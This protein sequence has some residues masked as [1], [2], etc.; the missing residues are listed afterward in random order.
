MAARKPTARALARARARAHEELVR[1]LER[2]AR[3]APG[4]APDRPLA[5]E[6]PAQVEPIADAQRCPLCQGTLQ[7]DEHAVEEVDGV[8][9]RVARVTCTSCGVERRLWFRLA[10]PAIN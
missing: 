8:L 2:L 4:G 10:A 9:L 6:S 7:L 1:D 3:L 5:I